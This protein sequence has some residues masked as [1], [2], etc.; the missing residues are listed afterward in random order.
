MAEI[1]D[2]QDLDILDLPDAD[3]DALFE[4]VPQDPGYVESGSLIDLPDEEFNKLLGSDPVY[5][6]EMGRETRR[7]SLLDQRGGTVRRALEGVGG[8]RG[9]EKPETR[10][11]EEYIKGREGIRLVE[12]ESPLSALQRIGLSLILICLTGLLKVVFHVKH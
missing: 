2:P 12:D 6:S 4:Q 10:R 3:F 9:L 11:A 1:N 8:I 7:Q 5:E